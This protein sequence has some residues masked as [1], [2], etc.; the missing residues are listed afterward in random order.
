[1]RV[2]PP[3]LSR[4][5]QEVRVQALHSLPCPKAMLEVTDLA[6]GFVLGPGGASVHQL[7]ALHAV[8]IKSARGPWG[9]T[10]AGRFACRQFVVEAD[11]PGVR[12]GR[13][14]RRRSPPPPG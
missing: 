14:R 12:A 1:M 4:E 13:A 5:D 8:R 9:H 11:D 10:A 2:R 6:A 3:P 7:E